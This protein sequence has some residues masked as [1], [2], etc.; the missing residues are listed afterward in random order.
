M[1][2]KIR[3]KTRDR[4]LARNARKTFKNSLPGKEVDQPVHQHFLDLQRGQDLH[5]AFTI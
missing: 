3:V 5:L 1:T 4:T 2:I